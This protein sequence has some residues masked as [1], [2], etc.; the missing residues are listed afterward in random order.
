MWWIDI[1]S[2]YLATEKNETLSFAET[3][4]KLE[5]IK[6]NDTENK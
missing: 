2:Y 4:K 1:A 5:V 3:L 6:L